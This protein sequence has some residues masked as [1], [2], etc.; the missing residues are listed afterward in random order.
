MLKYHSQK[1]A[2]VVVANGAAVISKA[3]DWVGACGGTTITGVVSGLGTIVGIIG[4]SGIESAGDGVTSPVGIVGIIMGDTGG[5][6]VVADVA[7]GKAGGRLNVGLG[8]VGCGVSL[9]E[10]T[11]EAG[12]AEGRSSDAVGVDILNIKEVVANWVGI[13]GGCTNDS[14]NSDEYAATD[15]A[16]GIKYTIP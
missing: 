12:G 16:I 14:P 15:G 5:T 2:D 11:S 3:P 9:G 4:G 1:S 10:A 7:I 13:I 6:I 8:D